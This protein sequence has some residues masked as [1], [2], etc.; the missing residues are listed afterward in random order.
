MK[1][2]EKEALG[3]YFM[4]KHQ[5]LENDLTTRRDVV[6]WRD[7]D[8]VDCLEL[9]ISRVRLLAFKEFMRDVCALLKLFKD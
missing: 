4:R 1:L 2:T 7:S 9:M 8:E 3:M 6:R 5:Q